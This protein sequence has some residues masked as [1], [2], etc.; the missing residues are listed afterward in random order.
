MIRE[1]YDVIVIGAGPAGSIAARTC[2]QAGLRVSR[3]R[4]EIGSPVRMLR[5]AGKWIAAKVD[6]L[7]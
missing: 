5:R 7:T 3:K 6:H 4:Q 2:A 1:S